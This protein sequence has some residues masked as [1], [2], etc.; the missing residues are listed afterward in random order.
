MTL[1][2]PA[3]GWQT[4]SARV[5]GFVRFA[6]NIAKASHHPAQGCFPKTD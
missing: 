4:A 1:P 3:F 5:V 2:L 6:V